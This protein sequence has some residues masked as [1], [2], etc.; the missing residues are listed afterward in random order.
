MR[1]PTLFAFVLI[2]TQ[3]LFLAL[4]GD[5]A[6]GQEEPTDSASVSEAG[7]PAQTVE[8]DDPPLDDEAIQWGPIDSLLQNVPKGKRLRPVSLYHSQLA[9][10]VPSDFQPISISR[11][12][13]SFQKIRG[14][15]TVASDCQLTESLYPMEFDG[16]LLI[17]RESRWTIR[18]DTDRP[19]QHPIGRTNLALH[20]SAPMVVEAENAPL[21]RLGTSADGSL[22]AMVDGDSTLSFSWSLQCESEGGSKTFDLQIPPSPQTR[23]V[24]KAPNSFAFETAGGVLRRLEECPPEFITAENNQEDAYYIIEAGG[25]SRLQLTATPTKSESS[26]V[27]LLVRSSF[28]RYDV[29]TTRTTWTNQAS[30]QL[31]AA[32]RIPP[33]Q[34]RDSI[35]TSVKLDGVE[36]PFTT[37]E[38]EGNL[39]EITVNADIRSTRSNDSF[40]SLTISGQTIWELEQGWCDLPIPLFVADPIVT[41]EVTSQVQLTTF[42]P[43]R[44]IDW[45]LPDGW[46]LKS[47]SATSELTHTLIAKGTPIVSASSDQIKPWSRIRIASE[48]ALRDVTTAMKLS[49]SAASVDEPSVTAVA[50]IRV[51]VDPQRIEPICLELQPDWTLQSLLLPVSGRA[52]ESP[53]ATSNRSQVWIWPEAADVFDSEF[54]LRATGIRRTSNVGADIVIPPSWF[55][56]LRDLQGALFVS[57]DPPSD[58]D[59]SSQMTLLSQQMKRSSLPQEFQVFFDSI[60]KATIY[61][62]CD[63][64]QTPTLILKPLSIAF[65]VSTTLVLLEENAQIDETFF[66]EMVSANQSPEKVVIQS[67]PAL[68]RPPLHWMLHSDDSNKAVSLSAVDVELTEA[69]SEGIYT[70]DLSDRSLRGQRLIGRRHYAMPEQLSVQLP[71]VSNATSQAADAYLGSGLRLSDKPNTVLRVPVENHF[72]LDDLTFAEPTADELSEPSETSYLANPDEPPMQRQASRLTTKIRYNPS[73]QPKI[74]ISKAKTDPNPTMVWKKTVRLIAS[75]QGSDRLEVDLFVSSMKPIS[76]HTD[77]DFQLISAEQN[78]KSIELPTSLNGTVQIEPSVLDKPGEFRLIWIRQQTHSGWLRRCTI[79]EVD[80]SGVTLQSESFVAPSSDSFMPLALQPKPGW[81]EGML[82]VE[83]GQRVHFVRRDVALA[84]GSLVAIILFAFTWWVSRRSLS[85][86]VFAIVLYIAIALLWWPWQIIVVGWMIVPSI[87]AALMVSSFRWHGHG[88]SSTKADSQEAGHSLSMTDR[89]KH[90]SHDLSASVVRS[91]LFIAV[92]FLVDLAPA[93]AQE[94]RSPEPD[95][96]YATATSKPE[97]SADEVIDLLIPVDAAGSMIG[98][99]VYLSG[100][101]KRQVLAA[102]NDSE[103][104]DVIFESVNY[105]MRIESSEDTTRPNNPL[106]VADFFVRTDR[107]TDRIRLPIA[108]EFIRRI[109]WVQNDQNRI[110]QFTPDV[111]I[112]GIQS[113]NRFTSKNASME[114]MGTE[115]TIGRSAFDVSA[116]SGSMGL[117]SI[118]SEPAIPDAVNRTSSLQ[119][120]VNVPGER[121]MQL[122]ITLIPNFIRGDNRAKVSLPV[123]PVAAS[124]FTIEGSGNVE[125]VRFEKAFG[126]VVSQRQLQLWTADVGAVSELSAELQYIRSATVAG[127]RPLRRRYWLHAGLKQT[128]VE[129]QVEPAFAVSAGDTVTLTIRDSLMPTLLSTQWQIEQTNLQSPTRREVTLS[130]RVDRPG[131]IDLLWTLA[132]RI[133]ESGNAEDAIAIVIPDVVPPVQSSSPPAWIAINSDPSL[134]VV[135]LAREPF[136][137]LTDDQFVAAWSGYRGQTPDRTFVAVGQIPTFQLLKITESDP[138]IDQT[139]RLHISGG[140]ME[141]RYQAD[142][143]PTN[144]TVQRWILTLPKRVSLRS[145]IIDG[146]PTEPK[147]IS[148]DG[149][150][151]VL[152]SDL[153]DRNVSQ[154]QAIATTDI[155]KQGRFRLPRLHLNPGMVT[156]DRYTLTRDQSI[157]IVSPSS[158]PKPIT[159]IDVPGE[160]GFLSRG[161]IPF[162]AYRIESDPLNLESANE[163]EWVSG[164]RFQAVER[165]TPFDAEQRISLYWNEGRWS[166]QSDI[167]LPSGELPAYLDFQIPTRWCERLEVN[168]AVRWSRQPAS[169][170]STQ[171]IRIACDESIQE[172]RQITISGML[173]A[174]DK[175]RVSVPRIEILGQGERTAYISVPTRLTNDPIRWRSSNVRSLEKD[176]LSGQMIWDHRFSQEGSQAYFVANGPRWSI[177]LAPIQQKNVVAKAL[178]ADTRVYSNR[179]QVFVLTRWEIV[180]G[181]VADVRIELPDDAICLAALSAH[182]AVTAKQLKGPTSAQEPEKNVVQIPLALSRLSQSV[183][184]LVEIPR[185]EAQRGNYIPELLDMPVATHWFSHYCLDT[186]DVS[187]TARKRESGSTKTKGMIEERNFSLASALNKM[188]I[189]SADTLAERPT[190]ETRLWLRPIVARYQ[191]LASEAGFPVDWQ[192]ASNS[193]SEWQLLHRQMRT[194]VDRYGV[195]PSETIPRLTSRSHFEGFVVNEIKPLTSQSRQS[196]VRPSDSD[197]TQLWTLLIYAIAMLAVV[198]LVVVFYPLR[199][200]IDPVASH[201]AFWLSLLSLCGFF[202]APPPIAASLLLVSISLPVFP[203][204]RTRKRLS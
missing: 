103:P 81:G 128:M 29:D 104:A 178:V 93:I 90:D 173:Q 69:E 49:I 3:F 63:T 107:P 192:N 11:L 57:A 37:R 168:S 148:D 132:S 51:R 144:E 135:P 1:H 167:Q 20:D 141:I 109:E 138:M 58:L 153:S 108:P 119:T 2:V 86:V 196:S 179:S 122:R 126:E 187:D 60:D 150:T 40:V 14:T 114:S 84:F 139:H 160:T 98:D 76:V 80:V 100:K 22:V 145:L 96:S 62:S 110:L 34:V 74:I 31:N 137:A 186:Q 83:D 79:P 16:E 6:R 12:L 184:V 195:D 166:M 171:L 95:A 28:T 113:D 41:S 38:I 43:L 117:S 64:G 164:M 133:S 88:A 39:E 129:C 45:D 101:T 66:V 8:S 97:S 200:F 44:V 75:I 102:E 42:A 165:A 159:Q 9:Q 65:D 182:Q 105:R 198:A 170:I 125:R 68:K 154:V 149:R 25:L 85:I 99:K 142:V 27:A 56:R 46:H 72:Q 5:V 156:L 92:C 21:P 71:V 175:T 115:S 18:C 118:H 204:R 180:P 174:A 116:A 32:T 163:E 123:P 55:I 23:F 112:P 73:D 91:L 94:N 59:W 48:S 183:E 82:R 193:E 87:S 53:S 169:D 54:V 47:E 36:T 77:A 158:L 136:D 201:P 176:A 67:G 194:H 197:E 199:R 162:A 152:L 190:S 61:L 146:Q 157:D 188:V 124:R 4:A 147:V 120:L 89:S 24:L 131:T 161:W 202:V 189:E 30:L 172:S 13:Q 17:S 140:L 52:I 10:L 78:G 155:G 143:F 7:A 203:N 50:E 151:K 70:I 121:R 19:V 185:E 111:R 177:E 106:I 134:R 33:I 15:E 191:E 127:L 26:E 181:T 35:I 130:A